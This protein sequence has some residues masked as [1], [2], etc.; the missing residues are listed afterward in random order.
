MNLSNIY[1]L[2][3]WYDDA[4]RKSSYRI[5][6]QRANAEY[7]LT[8]L[9][10]IKDYKLDAHHWNNEHFT[11]DFAPVYRRAVDAYER[12]SQRLGVAMHAKA[13]HIAFLNE[14]TNHQGELSLA[15]FADV[16]LRR[17]LAAAKRELAVNHALEYLA[18]NTNKGLFY[19]KNN[20]GGLYHLTADE[21]FF[22]P[23]TQQVVIQ[24]SKNTSK[25][26][27]PSLNDIKDGLF[28]CLLFTNIDAL[29]LEQHPIAFRVQLVLTGSLQTS[30][31][32]PCADTSLNSFVRANN[33]HPRSSKILDYVN[34]EARANQLTIQVRPNTRGDLNG[35]S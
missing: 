33:L 5:T 20:L 21:V 25:A 32:L 6:K 15:N 2:L 1:I 23:A 13:K 16:T 34:A 17:S 19:I 3:V 11:R 31:T 26:Q 27:L 29:R 30:L 4:E 28:K 18:E 9:E 7:V 24:E 22:E 35:H 10:R 12:L 8:M 14:I